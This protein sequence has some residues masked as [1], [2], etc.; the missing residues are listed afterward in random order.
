IERSP[1]P[2]SRMEVRKPA[3]PVTL[4]R[5]AITSRGALRLWSSCCS[6]ATARA[7][8]GRGEGIGVAPSSDAGPTDSAHLWA[9]VS[10]G[11]TPRQTEWGGGGTALAFSL[12]LLL[13]PFR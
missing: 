5:T 8:G 7:R 6:R 9:Q 3:R 4:S 11:V 13:T 10:P 12:T 2:R 1:A